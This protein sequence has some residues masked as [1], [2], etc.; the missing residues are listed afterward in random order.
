M[1]RIQKISRLMLLVLNFLLLLIPLW[2]SI[3]WLFNDRESLAPFFSYS[4]FVSTPEGMINIAT[5]QLNPL[6]QFL[7]ICS[8]FIGSAP[9]LIGIIFLKKLFQNYKKGHIFTLE[10]AKKYQ[11][12]GYFFFLDAFITKPLS[13]TFS[14]IATTLN[15]SPGHRYISVGFGTPNLETIFCGIL[16]IIISWIMVEA[17]KL[18]DDQHLTI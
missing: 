10:N 3:I 13:D 12:L 8:S 11:Q 1:H 15:N 5:L 6:Q 7:G 9:L 18:Q 4:L 2:N 16:V 14:V 17:Q